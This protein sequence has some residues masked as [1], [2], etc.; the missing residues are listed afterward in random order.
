MEGL[1]PDGVLIFTSVSN[2]WYNSLLALLGQVIFLSAYLCLVHVGFVFCD[3]YH[4]HT[5]GSYV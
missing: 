3:V 5:L 4:F 2:A 1:G